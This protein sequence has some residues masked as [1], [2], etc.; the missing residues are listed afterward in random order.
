MSRLLFALIAFT[1]VTLTA[2]CDKDSDNKN[3][4]AILYGTWVKGPNSGDTLVF[5]R[6]NGR[7]VLKMN[8]SF[9][10]LMYA[11]TE[12]EYRLINGKLEI[13]MGAG[14]GDPY[15]T[16]ESFEW[17]IPG[18]QFEMLGFQLYMFMSSSIAKFTFTKID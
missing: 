17:K 18:Q 6:K 5:S 7:N 10:P 13:K 14:I 1:V 16:I 15:W 9:N 11:P 4:E 2:S 8:M 3:E 12:R